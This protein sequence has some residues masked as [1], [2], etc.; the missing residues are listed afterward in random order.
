MPPTYE[1]Y[2]NLREWTLNDIRALMEIDEAGWFD[3]K[4]TISPAGPQQAQAKASIRETAC[5]MA[6]TNGGF[7]IFG[8]RDRRTREA[9]RVAGLD[10]PTELTL[11]FGNLI[12]AITPAIQFHPFP[13]IPLAD[14]KTIFIVRIDVVSSR[15]HMVNGKMVR[16]SDGGSNEPMD[17]AMVRE[18]VLGAESR[19]A[20]LRMFRQFLGETADIAHQIYTA[21]RSFQHLDRYDPQVFAILLPDVIPSLPDVDR[22]LWK[23]FEID[24]NGKRMNML[25]NYA[26]DHHSAEWTGTIIGTPSKNLE[27]R[28]REILGVLPNPD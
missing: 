21:Q 20:R 17:I 9:V 27:D 14:D 25:L 2:L 12:S 22:N 18:Q 1:A 15:P 11:K 10:D 23:L 16:R 28:C 6:N 26:F 13:S 4:E 8:V 3:F 7:L 24:Q 19:R 5:A